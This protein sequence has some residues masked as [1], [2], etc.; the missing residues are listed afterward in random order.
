MEGHLE[1]AE[2]SDLGVVNCRRGLRSQIISS[3][4]VDVARVD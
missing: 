3:Q 4:L 1:E 2:D